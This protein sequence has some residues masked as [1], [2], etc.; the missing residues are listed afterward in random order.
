MTMLKWHIMAGI[1]RV[2]HGWIDESRKPQRLQA[3]WTGV[4]PTVDSGRHDH[5]RKLDASCA[6]L[7]IPYRN[8]RVS[9]R[10]AI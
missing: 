10:A 6:S 5:L 1:K 9:K 3:H 2:K 8:G 7:K 4:R